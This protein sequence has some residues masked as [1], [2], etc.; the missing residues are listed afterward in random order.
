LRKKI[1]S[2]SCLSPSTH[3]YITHLLITFFYSSLSVVAASR[4]KYGMVF[5]EARNYCNALTGNWKSEYTSRLVEKGMEKGN[6]VTLEASFPLYL[7][8]F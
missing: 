8:F 2:P 1:F 3:L 7:L 6:L 5:W 4:T